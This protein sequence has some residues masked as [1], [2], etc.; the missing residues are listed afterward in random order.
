MRISGTEPSSVILLPN[1][2]V[3]KLKSDA[4]KVVPNQAKT[5]RDYV[6]NPYALYSRSSYIYSFGK[7]NANKSRN[8]QFITHFNAFSCD[9]SVPG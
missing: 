9:K 2:V 4:P 5:I 7:R 3:Q 1:K 8:Q 6:I